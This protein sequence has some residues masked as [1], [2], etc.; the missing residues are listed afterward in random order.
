MRPIKKRAICDFWDIPF[1]DIGD[2]HSACRGAL[3]DAFALWIALTWVGCGCIGSA[4]LPW[5]GFNG[6]LPALPALIPLG[7]CA[8]PACL[9]WGLM[10][11]CLPCL[12]SFPWVGCGFALGGLGCS[13]GWLGVFPWVGCGFAL[14]GV[15]LCLGVL[16]VCDAPTSIGLQAD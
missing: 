1:P 12:P 7:C 3:I 11:L 13:L 16:G 2:L 5:V 8:S 4:C 14:G 10:A 6:S 9:G 15:W